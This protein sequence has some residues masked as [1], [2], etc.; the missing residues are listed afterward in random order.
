MSRESAEKKR[1][2]SRRPSVAGAPR[3]V[4][5]R[6]RNVR[7][8][9]AVWPD[10]GA[11][12]RLS[13]L[14]RDVAARTQG[15]AP[16]PDNLHVTLAFIGEIP[17]ERIEALCAIGA[18]VTTKTPPFVLTLDCLGTFPGTGIAWAGA[19]T[20]PL[21]LAQ[22]ARELAG[23]LLAQDFAV[24]RRAFTPHVTLARRCRTRVLATVGA[25]IAWTVERLV[26]NASQSAEGGPYYREVAS[27]PL[28]LPGV[29][30]SLA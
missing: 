16:R 20:L 4:A 17:P 23:A 25:P 5:E 24:E 12:E 7:V 28:A 27:W 10:R 13:T 19:S 29:A 26:L 18:A 6:P 22:L 1:G 11:Q 30:E 3:P 15:R 21:E 9:F 14:A 8:F 2:A